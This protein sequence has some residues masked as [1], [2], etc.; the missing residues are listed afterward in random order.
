MLLSVQKEHI[1]GYNCQQSVLQHV[2]YCYV[3]N[4]TARPHHSWYL[5]TVNPAIC[6]IIFCCRL[7]SQTTFQVIT[8]NSPYCNMW[9]TIMLLSV[10]PDHFTADTC[11]QCTLKY[12]QYNYVVICTARPLCS[13][14]LSTVHIA[15]FALLFCCKLYSQTTFQVIPVNSPYFNMWNT[16]MLLSVQPDHFTADTCQQSTLKYV[17]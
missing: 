12:V 9:N 1:R 15:V 10:Q 7:Y 16:I 11:Q 4:C 2:Q 8:V 5:S 13:W 6:A 3:A 14:Y 17:Q